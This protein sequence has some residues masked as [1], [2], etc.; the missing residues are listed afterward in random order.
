MRLIEQHRHFAEHGARLGQDGNDGIALD[1]LQPSFHQN[2]QV[3]GL[4][5][6]MQHVRAGGASRLVPPMQ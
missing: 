6:L 5:A 2:K 1:H 3:S 4:A